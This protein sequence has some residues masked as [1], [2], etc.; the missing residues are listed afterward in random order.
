[1]VPECYR[2]PCFRLLVLDPTGVYPMHIQG[3]GLFTHPYILSALNRSYI[4]PSCSHTGNRQYEWLFRLH[5]NGTT[6]FGIHWQWGIV[7]NDLI[8]REQRNLRSAK[9][10]TGGRAASYNGILLR[11]WSRVPKGLQ[12]AT[13]FFPGHSN[14]KAWHT[15]AS[16]EQTNMIQNFY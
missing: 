9:G 10:N 16:K 8:G 3:M 15:W 12:G 1:M 14:G 2:I 11:V 13:T 5:N 4:T 6:T 7:T